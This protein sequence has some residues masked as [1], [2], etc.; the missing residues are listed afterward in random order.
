VTR[1]FD[2]K[3]NNI[4]DCFFALIEVNDG[5][6]ENIHKNIV[7]IFQDNDIPFEKNLSGFAAVGA[8]VMFGKNNSVSTML[9]ED[10]GVNDF[11]TF[12]CICHSFALCASYACKKLPADLV[13]LLRNIYNYIASS[14]KRI[15]L[16]KEFQDFLETKPH[17]MLHPSQTRWLSMEA[18]VK[19]LLEQY[20]ALKLYFIDAVT[21]DQLDSSSNILEKLTDLSYKAFLQFLEF[22][23]PV[24]NNLNR[25]MQSEKVQIHEI[26]T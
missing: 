24:F 16:L 9:T 17:R 13:D 1:Y 23:L 5:T 14:P 4:V 6:A 11:Y 21:N 3:Y 19:Q 26:K 15:A 2:R 20:E 25:Q 10:T 22:I 12:K 18:V 8:S 7:N